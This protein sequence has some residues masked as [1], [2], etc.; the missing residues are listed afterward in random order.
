MYEAFT[1]ELVRRGP[2][3]VILDV[4]G[5]AYRFAV[6]LSTS[7]RLPSSGRVRLLAHLV[8][9]DD[10]LDLVGFASEPERALFRHLIAVSGI[11][12]ASALH[13]L[14]RST[15]GEFVRAVREED[16]S[17]LHGIRGIGK[18]TAD[19]ILLELAEPLRKWDVEVGG[20]TGRPQP[21][22]P[23]QQEAVAALAT[24]GVATA[25][26]RKAVDRATRD[27]GSDARLEDLVRAAL[28]AL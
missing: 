5:V 26:A 2:T 24:L 15:V 17:Y 3:E 20:E 16:R 18:K 1:G 21:A 4:Q 28:A 12:P 7:E 11:G 9:R 23:R 19:R 14:S 13:V 22:S 27:V 6:P 10:R 25:A 8:V